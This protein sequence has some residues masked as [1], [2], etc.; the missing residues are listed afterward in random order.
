M[1]DARDA[2]ILQGASPRSST[3]QEFER[4]IAADMARFSVLV[5]RLGLRAE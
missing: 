3:P 4:T 5:R 1:P 2:M